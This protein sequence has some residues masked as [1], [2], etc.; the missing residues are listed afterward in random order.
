MTIK[1]AYALDVRTVRMLEG[2]ARRW[3]VS[4]SEALRR[5]IR[6]AADRQPLRADGR[7]RALRELQESVAARQVDLDVWE[8]Q[9]RENRSASPERLSDEAR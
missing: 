9:A 3:N 2:L 6:N 7:L 5:A 4:K 8:R 1:S